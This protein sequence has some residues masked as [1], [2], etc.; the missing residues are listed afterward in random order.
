[1]SKRK[2][3]SVGDTYVPGD[4]N[5]SQ[6]LSL[7][8]ETTSNSEEKKQNLDT[9]KEVESL[10]SRIYSRTNESENGE[11]SSEES[12]E[13]S[14][15]AKVPI[16]LN[17]PRLT[18]ILLVEHA[19]KNIQSSIDS[20]ILSAPDEEGLLQM[21][22]SVTDE[23]NPQLTSALTRY[24]MKLA[25]KLKT[26]YKNKELEIFDQ[27]LNFEELTDA[28]TAP[29]P[30][31]FANTPQF[32][33]IPSA[34]SSTSAAST[35]KPT[36]S[37][38]GNHDKDLPPLPEIKDPAIRAR[39]FIHKSII[40]DKLFLSKR[41]QLHSHNERLE[42]L[43]DSVLNNMMTQI[44]YH[45]FPD[46]AE[47]VLS[48]LRTKLISNATLMRWSS[49]YGLDKELKKNTPDET[50]NNGKM[51]LYADVFEAY[52]GGLMTENPANYTV[53]YDWLKQLAEPILKKNEPKKEQ[54]SEFRP[55][56][57]MELYSLIGSASLGLHYDCIH[58]DTR[59]VPTT[60]IVELR[61]GAGDLLGTGQG[62]NI[63][64]AGTKAAMEALD[65]KELIEKYSILRANTPR[66][67]SKIPSH[68]MNKNGISPDAPKRPE[69][70]PEEKPSVNFNKPDS[71]GRDSNNSKSSL[72]SVPTFR[73][74]HRAP[75]NF[76]RAPRSEPSRNDRFTAPKGPKG[77]RSE[78]GSRAN[79]S[80]KGNSYRPNTA[81]F[82]SYRP[83][84]F[85][86]S[87][88]GNYKNNSRKN[89]DRF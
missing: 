71:N 69:N 76:N 74:D 43:G 10:V 42:F 19:V 58:R 52:I 15:A 87:H 46:A 49:A 28:L 31:T 68:E 34:G 29:K 53:V 22:K 12:S 79:S 50:L 24:K 77:P 14:K 1:M 17:Q 13:T 47:G 8:R 72:P 23:T 26:M 6:K 66:D 51:K 78:P 62:E 55:N 5:K 60:F 56:A 70:D 80:Y 7:S 38:F 44:A 45:R 9:S 89:N 25:A 3:E 20:I 75:V 84:G 36:S 57:K 30:M 37:S 65:N 2:A 83:G 16:D 48:V 88:R 85:N 32:T 54:R 81:T 11:E 59:S 82:D 39:V 27:I 4:R 41:E 67:A 35:I 86:G 64:I 21:Q 18:D 40:K 63:K 33:P 73:Q 61:T